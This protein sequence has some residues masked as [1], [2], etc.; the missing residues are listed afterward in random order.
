VERPDQVSALLKRVGV[1]A[2]DTSIDQVA[3]N[4]W[5]TRG[6]WRV[7]ISGVPM[8]LKYLSAD[9]DLGATVWHAHWSAG[10]EV[11]RHWNYWAREGLA[12]LEGITD[13]YG[14]SGLGPARAV[15]VDLTDRDCT[16]LLEFVDGAPAEQWGIADYVPAA[17][18]LGRAQGSYLA[19]RP[20]PRHPWL[21]RGF[22]RDYSREKPADWSLLYDDRP[23]D[24]PVVKRNFP[25]EL[26]AAATWLHES[27]DR[28]YAIAERL[29]RTLCHLDFWTKNL[30][31][32]PDGEIALLDWAFVGD[33][34]VGEDA[35]NLV[36]DA[37][38]DHF[39]P[40]EKLPEFGAAVLDGYLTGLR[41]AG[42]AGDARLVRLGM[43]AAAVKYDWQ[44]PMMLAAASATRQFRY[45]GTEEIDADH[46]F[47][48]RGRALL[49]NANTARQAVALAD[50]M[51]IGS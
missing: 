41:Q 49:H 12:Y 8:V 24:Q 16:L 29:P 42:W 38:L 6:I 48:E 35:G 11:P 2:T 51:G 39:V 7:S 22:L 15:S 27:R 19:G 45:G 5:L 17:E 20:L 46:R 28:L 50:E 26:R 30:I 3:H 40:A 4:R 33:G 44:T 32:R 14:G 13:A 47:W 18:A 21:S 36:P 9:R 31:R 23:W 25:A 10:S 34:A 1:D 37:V 43:W